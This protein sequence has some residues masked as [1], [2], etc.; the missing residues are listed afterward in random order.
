[1]D[2]THI[3]DIDEGLSDD[4]ITATINSEMKK[5]SKKKEM[6]TNIDDIIESEAESFPV[7]ETI[8]DVNTT[9]NRISNDSRV[10]T[11]S[12]RQESPKRESQEKK[13]VHFK[14][15]TPKITLE[16][17]GNRLQ[18]ELNTITDQLHKKYINLEEQ[19]RSEYENT[20]EKSKYFENYKTSLISVILFLL[21]NLTMIQTLLLKPVPTIIK[22]SS[23]LQLIYFAVVFAFIQFTVSAFI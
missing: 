10:V 23:V 18:E 21:L 6:A 3:E 4:E 22:N 16:E 20:N 11:D 8:I 19:L 14:E 1:M 5:Y 17:C 2:S 13:R 9:D 12:R 15:E 7:A